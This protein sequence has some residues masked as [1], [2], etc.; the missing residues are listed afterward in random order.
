MKIKSS[1]E[2]QVKSSSGGKG[3][4]PAP[5]KADT[6]TKLSRAEMRRMLA[7]AVRLNVVDYL[8]ED[9]A[10]DLERARRGIPPFCIQGF[11][12]EEVVSTDKQ[13][14]ETVKRKIRLSLVDRL[15]ALALDTDLAEQEREATAKLHG[16]EAQLRKEHARPAAAAHAKELLKEALRRSPDGKG[17]VFGLPEGA[18]NGDLN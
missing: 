7:D 17:W 11:T 5:A 4:G 2:H 13:G 10:F 9:G 3:S 14:V 16:D 6:G 12:I 15:K 18:E 1:L 8:A